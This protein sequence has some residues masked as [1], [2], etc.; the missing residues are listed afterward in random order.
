[1]GYN[2]GIITEGVRHMARRKWWT[3]NANLCLNIVVCYSSNLFVR[4]KSVCFGII[5]WRRTTTATNCPKNSNLTPIW[6]YESLIKRSVTTINFHVMK[7]VWNSICVMGWMVM[8]KN[9][10]IF[11]SKMVRRSVF[12]HLMS[13]SLCVEFLLVSIHQTIRNMF[14]LTLYQC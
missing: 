4:L 6:L 12:L 7:V 5:A 8:T 3:F 9:Y 10:I 13:L 2:C 1:M 14:T 11:A